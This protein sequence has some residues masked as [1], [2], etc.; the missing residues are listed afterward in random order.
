MITII[1]MFACNSLII[2]NCL[3]VVVAGSYYRWYCGR[4]KR[5]VGSDWY[6]LVLIILKQ[7]HTILVTKI[8]IVPLLFNI[9]FYN[10]EL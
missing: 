9:S 10:L 4:R 8:I 1:I 6:V 3:M 5:V 2:G 7:F